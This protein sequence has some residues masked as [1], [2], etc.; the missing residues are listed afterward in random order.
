M[1]HARSDDESRD[2]VRPVP[3]AITSASE[4]IEDEGDGNQ[5]QGGEYQPSL[6]DQELGFELN[7]DR[8]EERCE[9]NGQQ[10]DGRVERG[11][12]ERLL[13][14]V[15]EPERCRRPE[16]EWGEAIGCG[17]TVSTIRPHPIRSSHLPQEHQRLGSRRLPDRRRQH[18]VRIVPSL[19]LPNEEPYEPQDRDRQRRCEPRIVPPILWTRG[20]GEHE[21]DDSSDREQ[22]PDGIHAPEDLSDRETADGTVAWD[23]EQGGAG[24]DKGDDG[25][26]PEEPTPGDRLEKPACPE[27]TRNRSDVDLFLTI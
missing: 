14:I 11:A 8:G 24:R 5:A 18:G 26:R 7:D 16:R 13:P 15:G 2:V 4:H 10:A 25:E 3:V 27:F 6:G 1:A 9:S 22:Q 17:K 19:G 20:Q 12:T 23:D 21:Q